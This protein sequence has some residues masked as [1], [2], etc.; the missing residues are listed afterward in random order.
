M[1]LH[2]NKLTPQRRGRA[3]RAAFV[4]TAT[5]AAGCSHSGNEPKDPD[6]IAANP[7]EPTSDPAP[8]AT[9]ATKVDAAQPPGSAYVPEPAPDI[10]RNPPAPQ[11]SRLTHQ[12]VL[13]PKNK[14]GRVI[15][16]A[17]QGDGC[18]VDGDFPKGERPP[19]GKAPPEVKVDCP[20][21]LKDPAYESCRG[22]T[23][24][25]NDDASS[26]GCFHMGNPPPPPNLNPCP[27]SPS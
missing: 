19:P 16:R 14:A 15:K 5:V 4:V 6:V 2:G 20:A 11:V 17:Y 25:T 27:K 22:G 10:H 26:C 18:F 1:F 13:N 21:E 3:L 9:S 8:V 24:Q 23:L 7:P 12:K